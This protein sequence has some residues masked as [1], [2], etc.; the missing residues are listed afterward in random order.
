MISS[1]PIVKLFIVTSSSPVNKSSTVSY[2]SINKVIAAIELLF[3]LNI[4]SISDTAWSRSVVLDLRKELFS[5]DWL[6]LLPVLLEVADI[7]CEDN[8]N[9]TSTEKYKNLIIIYTI[10][11][12]LHKTDIG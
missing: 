4:F 12:I 10:F 7:V 8:D 11:I 9:P 3:W 2:F 1:D 6:S 5:V